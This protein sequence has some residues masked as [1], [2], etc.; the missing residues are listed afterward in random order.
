MTSILGR[1]LPRAARILLLCLMAAIPVGYV[2]RSY[3]TESGFSRL[4]CFG[5]GFIGQAL[6]QVRACAPATTT[7][8][9]YD[10]QFYCQV[11]TDPLLQNRQALIEAL[12]APAYRATR[13]FLPW[14]AYAAGLGRSC[15]I[16]QAYAVLN[17]GFW[18][19]LL[20]G[21][22]YFLRPRT[23]QHFLCVFAVVMTSGALFSL[24]RALVDL[25]AATLAF[26]AASLS[27]SGAVAAAV[28]MLLT[29]ETYVFALPAVCWPVRKNRRL[30]VVRLAVI[31]A[32]LAVWYVYAHVRLG[33]TG[34]E[35]N[36]SWPGVGPGGY[37]VQAWRHWYPKGMFNLRSTANLLA[38]ISLIVQACHLLVR[39]DTGSPYWR[40]GIGFVLV[41]LIN[42]D[43]FDS[44]VSFTRVVIP[45]TVAF[46]IGLMK[47]SGWQFVLWLVAGNAG[48][49]WGLWK[50]LVAFF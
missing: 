33:F 34:V 29:K 37:L 22:N 14:L 31:L 46:N 44:Q 7:G 15:A 28:M 25:P 13:I 16:I 35:A 24:H 12:D 1:E 48:L 26:Y 6:P 36:V 9:G 20:F 42:T 17:L 19:L 21:M 10:G 40:M 5:S 49:Y 18:F 50:T 4:V 47:E 23:I 41:Y 27:G 30:M 43:M 2:L 8:T 38:P 45:L 3:S 11:A 39:R 32:P